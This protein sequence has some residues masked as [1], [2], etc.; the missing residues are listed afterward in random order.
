VAAIGQLDNGMVPDVEEP[1]F[2]AAHAVDGRPVVG[3]RGDFGHR[4]IEVLPDA[5]NA[6]LVE[7]GEDGRQ[8][9]ES[10]VEIRVHMYFLFGGPPP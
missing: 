7:R 3:V 4:D 9:E 5:R 8:R 6:A 1:I 10:G 2:A